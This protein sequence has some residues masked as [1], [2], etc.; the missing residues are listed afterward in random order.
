MPKSPSKIY[1]NNESNIDL[2]LKIERFLE[3]EQLVE[4]GSTTRD[5]CRYIINKYDLN[6]SEKALCMQLYRFQ[7]NGRKFDKR[8]IF[9][10]E[11]ELLFVA[12]LESFSLINRP[13]DRQTFLSHVEAYLNLGHPWD[14]SKWFRDFL[15]RHKHRISV[16]VVKSLT[17]NR[18][19]SIS[20]DYVNEFIKD[21]EK[22]LVEKK[23]DENLIFNAD[24][25]RISFVP[26]KMQIKGIESISKPMHSY[27][28][29]GNFRCATYIPFF[30]KSKIYFQ[31]IIL[32]SD[33][34]TKVNISLSKYRYYTRN[35]I[36]PTYFA[37][38]TSGYLDSKTWVEIIK[39]F[40]EIIKNHEK[41]KNILILLDKLA[42]HSSF[43]SVELLIKNRVHVL[44]IPAHCTHFLQ[45]ADQFVFSSFKQHLR[46]KYRKRMV[47][48][49]N[50]DKICLDLISNI[51]EVTIRITED[52]I[53]ASWATTG[54]IPFEKEKILNRTKSFNGSTKNVTIYDNFRD[55]LMNI[56]SE[57]TGTSNTVG[58]IIPA[59]VTKPL[60]P[61]EFVKEIEKHNTEIQNR[62][63]I[64]SLKRK[65]VDK[66][67]LKLNKK[68]K[69][70]EVVNLTCHCGFHSKIKSRQISKKTKFYECKSCKSF[71]VCE[72]CDKQCPEYLISHENDCPYF[73]KL[74]KQTANQ[75]LS[76]TS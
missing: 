70:S 67:N 14:A 9:K 43:E 4:D 64:T 30:N 58:F 18:F 63:K 35:G 69:I 73:L 22:I 65:M 60:L 16:K 50:Q 3:I 49:R 75:K 25:C 52:V 62:N 6:L 33:G 31:V 26:K 27:I 32:P 42:I 20:I 68:R 39:K 76:N 5:A 38:T 74:V 28:E 61:D 24:E 12:I 8:C 55:I 46:K 17:H 7:S 15:N 21:Y 29:P 34:K 2:G 10:A 53:K 57:C 40:I 54:L 71:K 72:D 41:N 1:R 66:N 37:T 13:L 19:S 47:M 56:I 45:P 51:D 48:L 11:E 59:G 44:Y 36:I 23:I